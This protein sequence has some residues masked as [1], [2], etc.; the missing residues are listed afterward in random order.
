M[1]WTCANEDARRRRPVPGLERRSRCALGIE[2]ARRRRVTRLARR[3]GAARA[4]GGRRAARRF[5]LRRLPALRRDRAL[6]AGDGRGAALRR[7]GW[8]RA[9]D[10]QRLPDPLRGGAAAG[11]A[12]AERLALVHL[13]RRLVG[14]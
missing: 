14:G 13:S 10:L 7:R 11:G 1:R 3:A 4:N 5:F 2:G 8:A 9:R 12:E 6:L